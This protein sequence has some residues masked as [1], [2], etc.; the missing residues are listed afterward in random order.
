MTY[1]DQ[2]VVNPRIAVESLQLVLPSCLNEDHRITPLPSRRVFRTNQL[3]RGT[4]F[5]L[6]QYHL[7][8]QDSAI[9]HISFYAYVTDPHSSNRSVAKSFDNFSNN[10]KLGMLL[11]LHK[12]THENNMFS[13]NTDLLKQQKNETKQRH[14]L[15]KFCCRH[16]MKEVESILP[17][18]CFFN[19]TDSRVKT[20]GFDQRQ[21][22]DWTQ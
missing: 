22:T 14:I 8:V 7:A 4:C 9:I 20:S 19:S 2:V 18:S 10:T 15:L 6:V 3:H 5:L 11:I 12:R 1:S 13:S 21:P 17:G 16:L